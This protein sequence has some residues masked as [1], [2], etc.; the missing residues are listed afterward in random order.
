MKEDILFFDIFTPE[1][2]RSFLFL[3]PPEIKYYSEKYYISGG[4]TMRDQKLNKLVKISILSAAAFLL[5]FFIEIPL[6]IFPEFLKLDISDLP[7]ILGAFALGP[8]AGIYIEALKNIFHAI[9]KPGTMGIGELANFVVG[10]AFVFTVGIIYNLKKDRTHALYGLA[11]GIIV[12]VIVAAIGNYF[13][14]LPLY[15][16]VLG[17]QVNAVIGMAAKVNPSIKDLNSLILLSI[18]PFNLLK[19]IIVALIA[20]LSYKS[21]SPILHK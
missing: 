11:A 19:G 3:N 9:A 18:V 15:E 13:V 10:G 6:P 1:V 7:A 12:M 21:M 5:M 17:F 2:F 8:A 14:F 16:K 4:F 20:F